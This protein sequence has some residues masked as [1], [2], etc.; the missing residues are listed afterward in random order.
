MGVH[1]TFVRSCDLDEWRPDQLERMKLGGNGNAKTFFRQHGNTIKESERKYTHRVAQMYKAHLD[2]LVAAK[3]QSS[4]PGAF[5]PETGSPELKP[6][7]GAVDGLDALLMGLGNPTR[8]SDQQQPGMHRSTSE[9]QLPDQTVPLPA[10]Q[11]GIHAQTPPPSNTGIAAAPPSFNQ[12]PPVPTPPASAPGLLKGSS[13]PPVKATPP[14][15]QNTPIPDK[16]NSPAVSSAPSSGKLN[17]QSAVE[18]QSKSSPLVMFGGKTT[19]AAVGSTRLK[20]TSSKKKKKLGA[21]KLGGGA[22]KL[23]D[24]GAIPPPQPQSKPQLAVPEPTQAEKQKKHQEEEDRRLA[25]QIQQQLNASG[26]SILIP[27]SSSPIS[28]TSS[29]Y[30]SVPRSGASDS[31]HARSSYSNR[32]VQQ[33]AVVGESTMARDK[34]SSAKGISSDQFFGNDPEERS[35]I[36]D[37]RRK[38]E[39]Y[40]TEVTALGSDMIYG[41]QDPRTRTG[42]YGQDSLASQMASKAAEDL[43]SVARKASDMK[44]KASEF[45]E[46]L[47][48]RYG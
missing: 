46:T 22:V 1:I 30:S 11:M 41:N 39:G 45:F 3:L 20:S 34:Y 16:S 27:N 32:Q 8:T 31:S 48:Y 7:E 15:P 29:K 17:V 37:A 13:T 10:A 43:Q 47:Q 12:P 5:S 4:N 24:F 21:M 40:G 33:T 14:T 44:N 23:D 18:G 2:K 35:E 6:M 36:E 9:P 26:S 42:S 19:G 28:S 25:E 38:L